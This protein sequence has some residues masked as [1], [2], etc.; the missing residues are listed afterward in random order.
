MTDC[1]TAW[2]G[3]S[4]GFP[5]TPLP[6]SWSGGV[7]LTK[8]EAFDR[9]T[10]RASRRENARTSAKRTSTGVAGRLKNFAPKTRQAASPQRVQPGIET[11]SKSGI[12]AHSAGQ[13]RHATCM[14][15]YLTTGYDASMGSRNTTMVRRRQ[16]TSTRGYMVIIARTAA[17]LAMSCCA[18]RMALTSAIRDR[19]NHSGDNILTSSQQRKLAYPRWTVPLQSGDSGYADGE[20]QF[21]EKHG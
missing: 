10:H 15:R 13:C 19:F 7:P 5:S 16:V 11:G 6:G 4:N 3:W 17:T 14:R 12:S 21:A 18:L 9:T 2:R 8:I 20:V 1:P